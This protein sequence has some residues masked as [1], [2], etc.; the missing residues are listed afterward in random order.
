VDVNRI[1]TPGTGGQARSDAVGDA[2][3][4]RGKLG[5]GLGVDNR[6]GDRRPEAVAA[7]ASGGEKT[8]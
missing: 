5:D 2:R 3:R 4:E 7:D 6:R 1:G 8:R